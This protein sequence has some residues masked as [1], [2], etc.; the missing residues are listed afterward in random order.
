MNLGDDDFTVFGLAQR[1][2]LDLTDLANRWRALQAQVHPDR[3]VSAP[4]ASQRQAMQWAL[5]VNQAY[6]RLRD[7]LQR[8]AYLCELRGARVDAHENTAMPVT[9]LQQQMHWREALDEAGDADALEHLRGEVERFEAEL[10]AQAEQLL[11]MDNDAVSAVERVRALMFVTRFK[12]E[13]ERRQDAL[14]H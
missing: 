11:D 2:G 6:Q 9:F 12:D 8:A 1:Q 5:R 7:P 4:A 3:H 13:L 10:L 14:A